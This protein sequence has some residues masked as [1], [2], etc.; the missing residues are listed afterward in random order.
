MSGEE[1]SDD[2]VCCGEYG[3]DSTDSATMYSDTPDT[4]LPSG[5]ATVLQPDQHPGVLL[6]L[7]PPVNKIVFD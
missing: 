7:H 3:A 6:Y 4:A 2:K 5:L 1:R